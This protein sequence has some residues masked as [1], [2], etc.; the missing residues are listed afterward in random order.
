MLDFDG[1]GL[2][3][4][5][6]CTAACM[7]CITNSSPR[8]TRRIP[9]ERA[10]SYIEQ[11]VGLVPHISFTGGEIFIYYDELKEL[12]RYCTD[13]DLEV[14]VIT[15]AFWATSLDE[16][17]R[18]LSELAE[19]GLDLIAV[20][21]DKFHLP[22]I[23]PERCAHVVR[24]G[25]ELGL[26]V[27]V[28]ITKVKVDPW[29]EEQARIFAEMGG[30]V[31]VNETLPLGRGCRLNRDTLD[32]SPTPPEESCNMVLVPMVA[33]DQR[34]LACCGPALYTTP[35]SPLYLGS[36]RDE[37]LRT[38]LLRAQ[39]DPLLAAILVWGPAWLREQLF[40]HGL[41][42][43]SPPADRYFGICHVC[44]D[45]MNS[46]PIVEHLYR[47]LGDQDLRRRLACAV[48][49]R[50]TTRSVRREFAAH[51]RRSMPA[52]GAV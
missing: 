31:T 39:K 32:S 1:L 25:V 13:L 50:D 26:P 15:N 27:S 43:L 6:Q 35:D 23:G 38:I 12:V 49:V 22:W 21:V 5:E 14:S 8:V 16:A 10:R 37:D 34:V 45:L 40:A 42:E 3:Y 44:L 24:A 11:S 17:R 2:M 29:A 18:R 30:E 36:T 47:I 41:G 20:S 46:P 33:P 51:R 19:R 52:P 7:H 9:Y 4:T 48:L 28:R